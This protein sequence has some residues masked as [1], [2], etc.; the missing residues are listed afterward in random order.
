MFEEMCYDFED[1]TD[2]KN[3]MAEFFYLYSW[4]TEIKNS[5]IE[6]QRKASQQEQKFMDNL[7]TEK[8]KFQSE[9]R[10]LAEAFLTVRKFNDYSKEKVKDYATEVYSLNDRLTNASEKVKS[11]N[12]REGLFK[13]PISDYEDLNILIK[14]FSAY[15]RLWTIAM[16]FDIDRGDWS[17][18]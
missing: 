17:S 13:Q 7:E 5:V 18:G 12:E 9:L 14:D 3:Y 11:F 15:H 6:G 16:D 10:D 4:P 2:E 1:K 8:D